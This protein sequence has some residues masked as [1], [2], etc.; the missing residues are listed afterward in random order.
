MAVDITA[1]ARIPGTKK[2]AGVAVGVDT[3]ETLVKNSRN[4]TGIPRV[5]SS[6]SPRRSVMK[7]S[8]PVWAVSG[9][10]AGRTSSRRPS[11]L[12]ASRPCAGAPAVSGRACRWMPRPQLSSLVGRP[13]RPRRSRRPRGSAPP[14]GRSAPAPRSARYTATAAVSAGLPTP[15]RRPPRCTAPVRSRRR[16]SRVRAAARAPV[17]RPGGAPKLTTAPVPHRLFPR[18]PGIRAASASGELVRRALEHDP[19]GRHDHD[20]VGH[21]LGLGQLVRRQHDAHAALLQ[22]GH[23][24]RARSCDP[25]GRRRPWARRGRRRP[26]GP[27]GPGPARAAVARP[28]TDDATASLPPRPARPGR[29]ARRSGPGRR[30]SRR[31]A[32]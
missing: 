31:T 15:A 27:P 3:T 28:P 6:V 10:H 30:S 7:N 9:P 32:R 22:P 24:G 19:P 4:T 5:S 12:P 18:R 25:R 8:A 14:P 11:T 26:A 13:C 1:S 23:H 2:L 29:A 20:P 16:G 21:L 17:S